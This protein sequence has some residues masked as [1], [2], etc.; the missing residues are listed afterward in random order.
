MTSDQM[1][2]TRYQTHLD[3]VEVGAVTLEVELR[4]RRTTH[5]YW[6]P[7][8]TGATGGTGAPHPPGEHQNSW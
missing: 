3:S 2:L 1:P 8:T 6:T 5:A 7:Y 4:T